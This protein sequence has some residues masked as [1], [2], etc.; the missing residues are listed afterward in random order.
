LLLLLGACGGDGKGATPKT[1]GGSTATTASTSPGGSSPAKKTGG[2]TTTS[3]K[4]SGAASAPTTT[5]AATGSSGGRPKEP[6]KDELDRVYGTDA[7][8]TATLAEKCVV[9]GGK[10]SITMQA[11]PGSAA[12]YDSYY[13]DGKSGV[14]EGFYGGNNGTTMGDSGTWSDTWVV[15]VG[16]PRGRV[17]VQVAGVDPSG[18]RGHLELNYTVIA[19]G[20]ACP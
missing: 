5:P 13:S 17:R 20:E 6:S 16:A 19:A 4:A 7:V 12:G 10:Q 8:V 11:P 18:H 1:A 15:G 9:P 14:Q 2:T 3:K